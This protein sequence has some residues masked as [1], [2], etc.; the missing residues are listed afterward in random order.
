MR[1]VAPRYRKAFRDLTSHWFRTMLVV[2]SIA[3]G[4]FAVGVMLGGREIL[5]REFHAD[6]SSSVP[7]SV[8]YRTADFESET[9]EQAAGQPGIEAAQARRSAS[10]RYALNGTDEERSITLEAF[11]DFRALDVGKVVPLDGAPWPPSD[12]EIVLEASAKIVDGYSVGDVLEIETAEGEVVE[13]ELV[14]FAH[15]I[16]AMPA[17]F[18]G[19]ETG[20]VTL[21]SMEDLGESRAFNQ[22]SLTFDGEDLTWSEASR[23]AVDIRERLFEDED[24]VVFYT[25]VPEPGS[26]FLGD[27]F[28]ALSLLLLAL[29]GLALGLSAFLVVNTVS[30]LMA[31]QVRQ[32]GIMKAVGGSA[33][34]LERLYA[35]IVTMYGLIACAV[36]LPLTAAGTQW[37]TDYAAGMLNFRVTSYAPPVWVVLVEVAVGML[38]PLLA[39]SG[40]VRRG[41]RMSVVRALNGTGINTA[42][43]GHGLVDRVLGMIRGLPRPV[44]L[45]LRNTFLRKG[46]LALTLSTLVLA[47]AVV[48]AVWS[49]RASIEQTIDDLE[50][51]WGFDLQLTLA[52]PQPAAE[53]ISEVEGVA[54]VTAAEAWSVFPA[55]LVRDDGSENESFTIVGLD[56]ETD[57]VRPHVVEGRWIEQGDTDAVVINT[58]AQNAE[59]TLG[60][61]DVLTLGVTGAEDEWR[62]VGVTKGQLGGPALYCNEEQLTEVTGGLGVTRVL[63]RGG[64][65]DADDRGD[66]LAS[67]E[68]ALNDAGYQVTSATTRVELAD[69]LREWLGILVAFLVLMATLLAAVGVIGLT[70]TMSINVLESTREIGVMRATG[71]QHKAIYQIY[72]TEGVTVGVIAWFLGALLTYPISYGLVLG[73][74]TA[75]GIPLTYTFSWWGLAGW[76]ALMLLISA[77]A[78]IAP[79]FRASQVSVRD[80]ISYE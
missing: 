76:L 63:V 16:N 41:V 38:V 4:I 21:D 73:L 53:V 37:F 57:F 23:R 52:M 19:H 31:Q 18:V 58:D 14:G 55:A 34:Q 32:V 75:I 56:P 62:V 78:S 15:D 46:R 26:H 35:V 33:G 65:A 40:P 7:P 9:V 44:A 80:A 69:Q 70:G 11:D 48:M 5:M 60:V 29:G 12:G 6:H 77:F 51:W 64:R 68:D 10:L 54:G 71:A 50:T 67:V 39:A 45:S 8:T 1:P 43:F 30:A 17:K 2:L 22:L 72:V 25:D 61:G 74:E 66:L 20:Y 3:I 13:F 28:D 79:A 27:I 59:S 49:V 47:S 24:I 36:G 42:R